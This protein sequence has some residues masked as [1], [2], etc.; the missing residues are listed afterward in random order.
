MAEEVSG[1]G[2]SIDLRGRVAVV[3]GGS[4]GIGRGIALTLARAGADLVIA[5]RTN[6]RIEEVCQEV[7]ALGRRA[8]GV[9][10]DV[11]KEEDVARL[12]DRTV[13]S[14]GHLDI[15]VNNAGGSYG[16]T[17]RR[18]PL[19]GLN[20]N[21]F[22]Q[23]LAVNLKSVFL[24]ST[25]VAPV[26]MRLGRGAIVNISSIANR[27]SEA[28]WGGFSLYAAAKAGVV[29]ITWSMAA[30]WAPQIRVNCVTPGFVSSGRISASRSA[31]RVKARLSTVS[32]GRPG[33][34][35][36]IGNAVAFLA[37]DAAS[38]VTGTVMD[39]HG[40]LKSNLPPVDMPPQ[41]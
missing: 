33:E 6:A 9:P 20:G 16:R 31:E 39:V 22:D 7:V 28:T 11:T 18:G 29:T 4:Q 8:L 19:L 41:V 26:M 40:G 3:T 2:P 15:L 10:T 35:E 5:S 24:C 21:D 38:Y 23:C 34:P 36:E 1:V 17:F 30:E 37:S 27:E 13:G 14:F 32:L 25:A 12:V